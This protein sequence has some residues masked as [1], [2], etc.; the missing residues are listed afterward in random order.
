[1]PNWVTFRNIDNYF[2]TSRLVNPVEILNLTV[3]KVA[4]FYQKRQF[5]KIIFTKITIKNGMKV[6][7]HK[8]LNFHRDQTNFRFSIKSEFDFFTIFDLNRLFPLIYFN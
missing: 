7:K 1:M 6:K 3:T 4:F 2:F 8:F 5:S